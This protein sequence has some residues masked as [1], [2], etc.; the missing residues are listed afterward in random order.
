MKT[1]A[2]S[3]IFSLF[4]ISSFGQVETSDPRHINIY[5]EIPKIETDEYMISIED[6]VSNVKYAK[7][8]IKITNKTSDYLLFKGEECTFVSGSI[9]AKANEKP[10]FIEPFSS[11]SKVIEFKGTENYHVDNFE[12]NIK[13]LYKIVVGENVFTAPDFQLPP[14]AKDFTAG[15]F[16]CTL[17]KT[18]QET[19][20]TWARFSCKYN[21]Q[22]IGFVNPAKCVVRIPDGKEF[23]TSNLKSK[24]E[25]FIPGDESKF[26]AV[27]EIPAKTTDMQFTT[28]NI[29]WKEA[30]SESTAIPLASQNA[31]FQ[32][33]TVKTDIKNKK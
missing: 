4:L 3:L 9:A 13:G 24:S 30:F 17:L 27:F 20:T 6:V 2:L 15:Q 14:S 33:D 1:A 5:N 26:T 18:E 10:V 12:V 29:I 28:M 22:K 32:V 23:A 19:Q 25:M 21:G 7:F 11:K 31:K 8:K 16:S